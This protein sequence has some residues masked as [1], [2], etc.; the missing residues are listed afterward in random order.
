MNVSHAALLP[1]FRVA[2]LSL[3]PQF[4]YRSAFNVG[5]ILYRVE[6]L[7]NIAKDLLRSLMIK[8]LI[9]YF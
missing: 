3:L 2:S 8:T 9:E 6:T 5:R 7:R 1:T 4:E